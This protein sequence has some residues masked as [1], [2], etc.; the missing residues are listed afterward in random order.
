LI[1]AATW[2]TQDEPASAAVD[3]IAAMTRPLLAQLLAI[4]CTAM[5]V[6]GSIHHQ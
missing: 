5:I 4:N 6:H 1:V 3:A 2:H